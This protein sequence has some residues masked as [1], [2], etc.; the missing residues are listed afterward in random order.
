M[1]RIFFSNNNRPNES[2]RFALA[3]RA[4]RLID[5]V[6]L[7]ESRL[8]VWFYLPL[9]MALHGSPW[10]SMAPAVVAANVPKIVRAVLHFIQEAG[11]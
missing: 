3:K 10:L 2:V 11:W 7:F 1:C 5:T 8:L 6:F 9:S 4:L